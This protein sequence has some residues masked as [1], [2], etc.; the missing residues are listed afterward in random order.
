MTMDP[1]KDFF[2][3]SGQKVFVHKYTHCA[4]VT[5]MVCSNKYSTA[6]GAVL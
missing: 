6:I 1:C 4:H 5:G 2:F 3:L